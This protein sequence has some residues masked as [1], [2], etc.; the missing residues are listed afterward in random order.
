MELPV[1]C[2]YFWCAAE[3]DLYD[4]NISRTKDSETISNA[5]FLWVPTAAARASHF[6]ISNT[7]SFLTLRT[8]Q[9]RDMIPCVFPVCLP[10]TN[11]SRI[12][13]IDNSF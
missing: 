9:A 12:R 8:I 4:W 2:E 1:A 11:I 5:A 6:S 13:C 7:I 10:A 3:R